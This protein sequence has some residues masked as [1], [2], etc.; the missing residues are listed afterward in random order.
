MYNPFYYGNPVPPELFI[1]RQLELQ[2]IVHRIIPHGQSSAIIG[3]PRIGKSSILKYLMAP[4][5]RD[6]LYGEDG[7]RLIFSRINPQPFG[8]QVCQAEFWKYALQPLKEQVI[9]SMPTASLAQAYQ[10]CQ[11]NKF[12]TFVLERLLGQV[13]K[14]GW[15]LV[16]LIDEFDALLHHPVLCGVEFF[17]GLRLLAS[18]CGGAL[19]LIIASRQSL[20]ELNRATQKFSR[21]SSPYFNFLDEITLGSFTKEETDQLLQKVDNYFSPMDYRFLIEIAGRHPYLLQAAAFELWE[22]YKQGDY[23][24]NLQR[25]EAA[26]SLYSKVYSVL[27]D[28]W[29]LWPVKVKK[30]FTDVVVSYLEEFVELPSSSYEAFSNLKDRFD[31]NGQNLEGNNSGISPDLYRRLHK[32]MLTCSHF[33]SNAALRGKFVDSRI[34]PWVNSLPQENNVNDRVTAVVDYL[35]NQ[36]ND[37]NENALVLLLRVIGGEF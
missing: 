26:Y 31:E 4:E 17:G 37:V 27:S 9:E 22:T 35:Y 12:G 36:Y 16:L 15:K 34:N 19:A 33:H 2:R 7:Q 11:Q 21:D 3:A 23:I 13:R 1:G 8:A 6:A 28:T 32:A 24:H 14:A 18:E 25:L 30:A 5:T 29:K 20:A 10:T